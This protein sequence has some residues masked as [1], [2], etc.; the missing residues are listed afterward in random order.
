MKISEAK[1]AMANLLKVSEE[2][3]SVTVSQHEPM[4]QGTAAHYV[5][6]VRVKTLNTEESNDTE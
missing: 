6:D 3:L 4:E 2:E 1:G 5:L